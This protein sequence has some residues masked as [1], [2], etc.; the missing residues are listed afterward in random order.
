MPENNP[1]KTIDSVTTAPAK[2][3]TGRTPLC[4]ED[5]NYCPIIRHKNSR[6][7]TRILNELLERYGNGVYRVVEGN[8]P[9]LTCC[10]DCSID[11]F[12]HIEGCEIVKDLDI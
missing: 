3:Y 1:T 12:C 2:E 5:C 7:V 11:D 4:N 10:F 9:N 6:V 8:C